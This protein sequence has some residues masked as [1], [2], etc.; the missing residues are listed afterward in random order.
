M[1][2]DEPGPGHFSVLSGGFSA[3]LLVKVRVFPGLTS[4]FFILVSDFLLPISLFSLLPLARV[5]AMYS[6][7]V[8]PGTLFLFSPQDPA[9]DTS[10]KLA[11]FSVPGLVPDLPDF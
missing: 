5:P 7:D 3:V 9:P 11:Q 4:F 2:R 1:V 8:R 6:H 10:D